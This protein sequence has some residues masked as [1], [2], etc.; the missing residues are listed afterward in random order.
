MVDFVEQDFYMKIIENEAYDNTSASAFPEDTPTLDKR[1]P[2]A[3]GGANFNLVIASASG[4][5]TGMNQGNFDYNTD[6]SGSNV[7]V[8]IVE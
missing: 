5:R 7:D 2:T 3:Q 8:Y 1:Y 4:K 6:A